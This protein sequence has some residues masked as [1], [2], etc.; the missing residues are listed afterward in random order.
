MTGFRTGAIWSF[1]WALALLG[2]VVWVQSAAAQQPLFLAP[3]P[4]PFEEE[5]IATSQ[6]RRLPEDPLGTA[7]LEVIL[8]AFSSGRQAQA[9]E[10]QLGKYREA[11]SRHRSVAAVRCE[12]EERCARAN[13][14]A[15]PLGQP[16]PAGAS[17]LHALFRGDD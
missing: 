6:I 14:P 17:H 12:S 2:P 10:S 3:A 15:R 8:D 1:R 11:G 5:T 16:V 4:T 9:L 13:A 7:N